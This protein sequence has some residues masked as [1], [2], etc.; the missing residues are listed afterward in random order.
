MI[1]APIRTRTAPASR[2][3]AAIIPLTFPNPNSE[4]KSGP[5]TKKT[6][7][8][9]TT[10]APRVLNMPLGVTMDL[11]PIWGKTSEIDSLRGSTGSHCGERVAEPQDASRYAT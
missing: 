1:T 2:I 11:G 6:M 4:P 8:I 5:K 10:I 7:P 9:N 3:R